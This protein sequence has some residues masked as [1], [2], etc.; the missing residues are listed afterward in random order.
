MHWSRIV[1]LVP[2]VSEEE[3][4]KMRCAGRMVFRAHVITVA[5][6]SKSNSPA[7]GNNPI[8]CWLASSSTS[9]VGIYQH[10]MSWEQEHEARL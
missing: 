10:A 6:L 4:A 1:G 9:I 8:P 5:P 7:T 3:N 2:V